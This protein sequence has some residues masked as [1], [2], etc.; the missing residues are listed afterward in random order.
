MAGGIPLV[1]AAGM[2]RTIV[3]SE[4]NQE[5]GEAPTGIYD[6]FVKNFCARPS[7]F[8][9]NHHN[10]YWY[11]QELFKFGLRPGRE[12]LRSDALI[13]I[14]DR[15]FVFLRSGMKVLNSML[16]TTEDA[17][18]VGWLDAWRRGAEPQLLHI[19]SL[20]R[21]DVAEIESVERYRQ[22]DAEAQG[23]RMNAV[24]K[25]TVN[26]S[27]AIPR[28]LDRLAKPPDRRPIRPPHFK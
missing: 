16:G 20:I 22:L 3:C 1:T 7:K 6:L 25:L 14:V 5:D 9:S 8:S 28:A 26:I 19:A 4:F 12:M 13:E 10:E 27:L 24:G 15:R 23:A 2:A 17:S 21:F 11:H 18:L